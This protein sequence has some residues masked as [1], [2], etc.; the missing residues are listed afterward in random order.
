MG[1]TRIL[2]A[3]KNEI[4]N[5]DNLDAF[6]KLDAL[7]LLDEASRALPMR[8]YTEI[9]RILENLYQEVDGI[10]YKDVLMETIK[11]YKSEI[12]RLSYEIPENSINLRDFLQ[13]LKIDIK[14]IPEETLNLKLTVGIDDGMGYTPCGFRDVIESYPEIEEGVLRIW[15]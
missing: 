6:S 1:N 14:G 4:E 2:E 7:F 10:E 5:S 11:K 3:I 9:V 13:S 15:I 12:R 8:N